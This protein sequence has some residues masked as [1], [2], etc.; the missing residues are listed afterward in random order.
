VAKLYFEKSGSTVAC[1]STEVAQVLSGFSVPFIVLNACRSG[2]A[3]LGPTGNTAAIFST[4]GCAENIL[5]MSFNALSVSA[6]IFLR[7]FYTAFL[8]RGAKF[9]C[10]ARSGR[11]ALKANKG[12]RGGFEQ[13]L[14]LLDWFVPVT[15]SA[16][17][18]LAVAL[19]VDLA[20]HEMQ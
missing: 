20:R 19:S 11:E 16:A 5:V 8:L 4:A 18:D 2:R 13:C 14:P 12:R 6:E 1:K 9:G 15:Y 3:D 10:A 17:E 7:V